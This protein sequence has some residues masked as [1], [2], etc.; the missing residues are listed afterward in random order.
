MLTIC[1]KIIVNI[2][3]IN[4]SFVLSLGQIVIFASCIVRQVVEIE[5]GRL[6]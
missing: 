1:V 2:S 5:E 6:L 3:T 4:Y